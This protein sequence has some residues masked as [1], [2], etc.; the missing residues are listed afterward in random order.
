ME[1]ITKYFED[2]NVDD[3]SED[4]QA[5]AITKLMSNLKNIDEVVGRVETAR[6]RVAKEIQ[7]KKLSGSKILS[8]RELPKNKRR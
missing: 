7:V 5:D 4:K 8:S 3:I 2:F 6:E 1:Q